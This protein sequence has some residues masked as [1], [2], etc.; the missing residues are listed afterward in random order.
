MGGIVTEGYIACGIYM[1]ND[2]TVNITGGTFNIHGGVGIAIRGGE[3]NARGVT[4][5]LIHVDG[6]HDGLVG[7]KKTPLPVDTEIV[8]DKT[9]PD[10]PA[11]DTINVNAPG[12]EVKTLA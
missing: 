4:F 3:L 8:V 11:A 5:N 9:K 6:I 10:Y 2:C 12:Y 7:D 1:A